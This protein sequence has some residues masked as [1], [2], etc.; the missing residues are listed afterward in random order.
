VSRVVVGV[1]AAE[2]LEALALAARN[3]PDIREWPSFATD[4]A[5]LIN[6]SNWNQL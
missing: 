3:P 2:Q 5:M 6:P 4:D 1:D